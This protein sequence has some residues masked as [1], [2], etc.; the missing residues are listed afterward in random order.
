MHRQKYHADLEYLTMTRAAEKLVDYCILKKR[1][2]PMPMYWNRL[3][4]LLP[5]KRIEDDQRKPASPLILDSWDISTNDEKR[6]RMREHI[7]WADKHDV[8]FA[9]DD[10]LRGLS[11]DE[12]HHED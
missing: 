11:E 6:Q 7:M 5:N 4:A 2:C 1:V 12:W 8:L 10:Y 9:I 3:Y